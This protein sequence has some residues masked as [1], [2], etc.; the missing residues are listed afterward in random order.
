MLIS[1]LSTNKALPKSGSVYTQA[2]HLTKTNK[3]RNVFTG[4]PKFTLL[5]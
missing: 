4:L 2:M 3:V 1:F 5:T